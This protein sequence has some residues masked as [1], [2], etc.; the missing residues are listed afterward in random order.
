M[1]D[2]TTHP[3]YKAEHAVGLG[4]E[5]VLAAAAYAADQAGPI[6]ML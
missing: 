2:A 4:P 3:A 5:L 1:K 6:N